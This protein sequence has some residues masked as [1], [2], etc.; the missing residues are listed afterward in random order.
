MTDRPTWT[1]ET[2]KLRDLKPW[3]V[4][5]RQIQKEQAERLQESFDTFGQVE[6]IAIGPANE[7]FNGHQ[8]LNVLLAQHGPDYEVDVRVSSRPLTEHE[9][10]KLTVFLHKGAI[11]EWDFEL[12]ANT[13]EVDDLI[14]WGFKPYELGMAGVIDAAGMWEGMPEFEQEDLSAIQIIKVNFASREDVNEF[15]RLVS[16]NIT[17]RTR[18]IWYPKADKLDLTSE[19]FRDGS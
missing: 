6:T 18:S 9:R 3:P 14:D 2:R 4:N 10:Q 11:G 5:P 17:D 8:R 12:L 1:T 13:F 19:V 7:V 16:Q 15:A